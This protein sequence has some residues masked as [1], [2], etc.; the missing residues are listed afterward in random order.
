MI[1]FLS[2][3]LGLVTG[4]TPVEL[5]VSGTVAE[6]EVR[7]DGDHVSQGLRRR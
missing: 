1:A 5:A 6:I 3:F 2:I 4:V 7:F